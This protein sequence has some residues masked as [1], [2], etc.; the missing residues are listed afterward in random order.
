M[1]KIKKTIINVL[2]I[3]TIFI[4]GL[5][6]GLFILIV[7]KLNNQA[8]HKFEI[9]VR[10]IQNYIVSVTLWEQENYQVGIDLGYPKCCV[11]AFCSHPPQ[12]MESPLYESTNDDKLRYNAGCIDGEFTGFIPCIDCAND[13]LSKRKTLQS[14]IVNRKPEFGEFKLKQH[15]L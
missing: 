10:L 9:I 5:T 2:L 11:D 15:E 8:K 1:K 3:V 13:V 14:L 7:I 4:L 12:L 6:L